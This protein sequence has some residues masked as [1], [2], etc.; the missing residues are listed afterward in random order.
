MNT[1]QILREPV[2]VFFP[3]AKILKDL[4]PN[5]KDNNHVSSK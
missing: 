1:G 4:A 3:E 5:P 2:Q